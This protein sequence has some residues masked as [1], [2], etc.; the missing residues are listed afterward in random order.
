MADEEGEGLE[1]AKERCSLL[2]ALKYTVERLLMSDL[3]N[4]W[5]TSDS[6]EK[7]I[8][9]LDRILKH[10]QR[11]QVSRLGTNYIVR[12]YNTGHFRFTR[13]LLSKFQ[14]SE[15]VSETYVNLTI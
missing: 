5:E 13:S 1:H 11:E 15:S 3:E 10:G 12:R 9:D 2:K 8:D 14:L 4:N 7:L 6:L